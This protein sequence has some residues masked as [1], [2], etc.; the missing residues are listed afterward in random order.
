MTTEEKEKYIAIATKVK[1][2]T[3]R[4][5]IAL[6]KKKGLSKYELMQM[7]IDTLVRY[8]DDRHN[9]SAEM[10]AAM[11]I[12]EHMEGWHGAFNLADY[13]SQP[14][15]TEATY[16]M[17]DPHK[18]GTRAVHVSKPYMGQWTQ[19]YNIQQIL[20]R[21]LCLLTPERYRRLRTLAVEMDCGS[22]LELLD[23]MIDHHT[24]DADLRDVRASF[25]DNDRSDYGR[26]PV[27]APYVRKHHKSPEQMSGLGELSFSDEE[28]GDDGTL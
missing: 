4:R 12:F 17:G 16:Y 11:S 26:K 15:V 18:R 24:K 21:T 6:E 13:T 7:V 23:V 28:G 22:L 20:E 9:L 8:M 2:E 27:S 3:A 5:L 25:E 10:E 14:E 19:T 1:P